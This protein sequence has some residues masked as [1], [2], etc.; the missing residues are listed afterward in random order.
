MH[1]ENARI[2]ADTL[3]MLML[4]P[5]LVVMRAMQRAQK[6]AERTTRMERHLSDRPIQNDSKSTKK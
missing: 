3:V 2:M 6:A 5:M 1:V 4:L